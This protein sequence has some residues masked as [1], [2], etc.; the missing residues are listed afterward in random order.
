MPQLPTS[1]SALSIFGRDLTSASAGTTRGPVE[2]INEHCIATLTKLARSSAD[3]SHAFVRNLRQPLC[4]LSASSALQV[5]RHPVLLVDMKFS[6][7]SW[8]LRAKSSSELAFKGRSGGG[9]FPRKQA[10]HLTRMTLTFAWHGMRTDPHLTQILLGC[11]KPVA[12]AIEALRLSDIDA[13]A[14][15]QFSYLRTRWEDRPLVWRQLLHAAESDDQS[16]MAR[17][18]LRSMQLLTAEMLNWRECY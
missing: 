8:W 14:E 2:E 16:K 17:C 9:P 15:S 13:I 3:C 1:G 12:E 11:T 6:D 4:R 18:S 10:A 5:T 7:A